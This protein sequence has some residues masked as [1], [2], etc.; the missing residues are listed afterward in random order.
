MSDPWCRIADTAGSK[1]ENRLL[2]I[3][4]AV[5]NNNRK[6]FCGTTDSDAALFGSQALLAS[7]CIQVTRAIVDTRHPSIFN[8]R[9]HYIDVLLLHI[10]EA[11][12]GL[13]S[14]SDRI[15]ATLL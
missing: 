11:D 12:R 1:G 2:G 10:G 15:A 3:I 8:T 6:G 7:I 13:F 14:D 9:Q 4:G 5:L